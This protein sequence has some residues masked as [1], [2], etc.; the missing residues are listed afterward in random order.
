[1]VTLGILAGIFLPVIALGIIT[2][3]AACGICFLL[4]LNDGSGNESGLP[5][6]LALIGGLLF[7]IPAWISFGIR[8]IF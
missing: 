1:L 4:S 8:H 2:A 7:F 5:G 6:G 3:V